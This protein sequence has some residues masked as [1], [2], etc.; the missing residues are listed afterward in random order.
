[1][2]SLKLYFLKKL[3][4]WWINNDGAKLRGKVKADKYSYI[5]EILDNLFKK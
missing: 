1:M 2:K 4:I 5:E 3:F